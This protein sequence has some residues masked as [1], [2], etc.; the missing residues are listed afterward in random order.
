MKLAIV[1]IA[2][3]M[4]VEPIL[5][6]TTTVVTVEIVDVILFVTRLS[7]LKWQLISGVNHA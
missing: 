4:S 1:S 2:N 5:Y 3:V 6:L 7:S